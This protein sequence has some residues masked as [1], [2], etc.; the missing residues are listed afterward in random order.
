MLLGSLARVAPRVRRRPARRRR[1]SSP[2]AS[3]RANE[4]LDPVEH[5]AYTALCLAI[6]N[7]DEALTK[8]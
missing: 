7:L 4:R 1:S 5:A 6:L 8:E 2:S 3:R